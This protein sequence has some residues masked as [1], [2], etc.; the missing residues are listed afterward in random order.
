M[1]KRDLTVGDEKEHLI[2]QTLPMIWGLL[3]AISVALVDTYYVSRL[4]TEQLAAMGFIFPVVMFMNSLAFGI[5]TGASSVIAQAIGS[6]QDERVRHYATQSLVLAVSISLSF[7]ALGLLTVDPLFQL[8]GA[9]VNILPFIHDYIDIWY[10]GCFLL[11]VPM[12]GNAGIRAAGNTLLASYIMLSVALINLVVAPVLIFGLLGFPRMEL[13]GAAWAGIIAYF[14]AFSVALYVL[15]VKLHF[16]SWQALHQR[17]WQ[18]WRD[19]LTIA[20]PAAGTNL[21]NPLAGAITT[22]LVASYGS[23]AVA[24]YSIASRIETF[25]IIVVMALSSILAPFAGQNWGAKKIDRLMRALRLSFNFVWIW[26]IGVTLLLWVAAEPLTHLFTRQ[27]QAVTASTDYLYIVPISY[28]FLSTVMIVSSMAT[29][30]GRPMPALIMTV[31]RL[32]LLYV[33]LAWVLSRWLGL[34]GL[35]LATAI[36]NAL[37][38]FAAWYWSAS[39]CRKRSESIANAAAVPA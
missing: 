27:P 15:R 21:I 16:I 19:I 7:A 29:G 23:A 11:V 26:G 2:Q 14:A 22:W 24:G 4:G 3:A 20:I 1:L 33:P 18:S 38:G 5:G 31:T 39:A 25:S 9:P 13:R 36:A 12:V 30:V 28:A 34:N 35:Y 32:L 10:W 17:V 6:K 37:V 8:L